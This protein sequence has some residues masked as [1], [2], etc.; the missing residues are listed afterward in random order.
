MFKD[1]KK[2]R[3]KCLLISAFYICVFWTDLTPC[4]LINVMLTSLQTLLCDLYQ[5]HGDIKDS[6]INS[7]A[8][9]SEF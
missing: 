1:Y 6:S 9:A 8:N 2:F 4:I 7:E 5:W 3:D